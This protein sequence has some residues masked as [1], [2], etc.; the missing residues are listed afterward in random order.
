MVASGNME[1]TLL[2]ADLVVLIVLGIVLYLAI[3]WLESALL[4][5][6]VSKRVDE[7]AANA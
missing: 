2:F 1:T 3:E 6:H 5:W 7:L 4:P